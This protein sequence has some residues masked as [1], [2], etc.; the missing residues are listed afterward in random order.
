MANAW[1]SI[2]RRGRS[3]SLPLSLPKTNVPAGISISGLPGIGSPPAA[4]VAIKAVMTRAGK[5]L[6]I[7][8]ILAL[9][10]EQKH[11]L[12]RDSDPH[13]LIEIAEEVLIGAHGQQPLA[14]ANTDQRTI[15]GEL[16]RIDRCCDIGIAV[17]AGEHLDVLGADA[18]DGARDSGAPEAGD[19]EAAGSHED[20]V[21]RLPLQQVHGRRPDEP[22]NEEG[23]RIVVDFLRRT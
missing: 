7:D 17:L 11:A 2:T 8:T 19:P 10:I 9:S 1:P 16:D 12:A 3:F 5:A 22:G 13:C 20:A 21:L 14:H 4:V 23:A 15:A 6:E 18:H